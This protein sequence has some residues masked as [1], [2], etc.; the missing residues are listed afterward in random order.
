LSQ[1]IIIKKIANIAYEQVMALFA[2]K[3]NQ[4]W[5]FLLDSCQ[6]THLGANFDILAFDPVL[7]FEYKNGKQTLSGQWIS[8]SKSVNNLSSKENNRAHSSANELELAIVENQPFESL[9]N[10]HDVFKQRVTLPNSLEYSDLPFIA[11]AL[12][13]CAYDINVYTDRIIDDFPNQ[14][15]LPDLS[16]GFYLQSIIYDNS[17]QCAYISA[18]NKQTIKTLEEAL[19][20]GSSA[21]LH[22]PKEAFV[23][24][25]D[26]QSNITQSQYD[27]K[28]EAI[29]DYLHAGDCYQV[30]FAQRFKACYQGCEW[31]AY[32]Q[33][34]SVNKAPF[35][36]FVRLPTSCILSLSPER[37]LLVKEGK[38]ETKPI[39]GTRKRADNELDDQRLANSL[40][41]S[42]KDR[43]ENLMIVDLLRNDLSKH[44]QAHTVKVPKLFALESYPAVHHMVSTVVG[45]LKKDAS[46]YQLLEG[47]F[48]GG[49][50][51]GAPKVRAMQIIQ[52]LEADKRSIYCGSIG[53]IGIRDDMDT[54][55]CIRT[56]LAEDE[57]LYCWAGGGIVID[58]TSEDEFQESLDKVAKILPILQSHGES[59]DQSK[60]P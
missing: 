23:L 47:A 1:Q 40:L 55:I 33:L 11:G 50:I 2:S 25:T 21:D 35:S 6:Q 29:S 54:N 34:K 30:N 45:L 18:T 28:M 10:L 37:F 49:S 46:P 58:S 51:T 36:S 41:A 17:E 60:E 31:Q 59:K 43:A 24:S 39:K 20:S 22:Q 44:C 3:Q 9:R 26:W 42:T 13:A 14:Y 12:C 52:E 38:V 4:A 57:Q 27:A 48:P 56:I 5:S 53:Y 15:K 7:T 19:S 8:D 16:L 32:E